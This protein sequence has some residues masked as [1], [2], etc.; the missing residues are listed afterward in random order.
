MDKLLFEILPSC[1]VCQSADRL[2]IDHVI[3]FSK[4]GKLEPGNAVVLCRTCNLIKLNHD[5]DNLPTGWREPIEAAANQFLEAWK[6]AQTM[7][8]RQ[9]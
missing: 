9:A 1:V 5:L 4:G 3:P 2:E 6:Q 7:D 8:T